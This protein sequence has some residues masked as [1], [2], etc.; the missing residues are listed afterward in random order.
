MDEVRG[1]RSTSGEMYSHPPCV[2]MS[3]RGTSTQ[4]LVHSQSVTSET[5]QSKKTSLLFQEIRKCRCYS[6]K[7]KDV[8]GIFQEI[9]G[10]EHSNEASLSAGDT[11]G[12]TV[13]LSNNTVKLLDY[14]GWIWH[15]M[16][17]MHSECAVVS[18][19]YFGF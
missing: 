6:K 11:R 17:I 2:V 12:F 1:Q 10:N 15:M 14:T 18:Q 7:L 3:H 19:S 4:S 9:G 5:G 8:A 16:V 13:L